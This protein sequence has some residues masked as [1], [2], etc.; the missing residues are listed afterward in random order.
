MTIEPKALIMWENT[1][2]T[3][4]D[5]SHLSKT[6]DFQTDSKFINYVDDLADYSLWADAIL[7]TPWPTPWPTSDASV[8]V[9]TY[10]TI[11][12]TARI[13]QKSGNTYTWIS[14]ASPYQKLLKINA[15]SKFSLVYTSASTGN[16]VYTNFDIGQNPVVVSAESLIIGTDFFQSTNYEIFLYWLNSYG[17]YAHFKIV[18]TTDDTTNT[19]YW[20]QGGTSTTD[21]GV[22]ITSPSGYKLIAMRLVGGFRTTADAIP[23]IDPTSVWDVSTFHTEVASETYKV[24][25]TTQSKTRILQASDIPITDS[26]G[27]YN[28]TDS[29]GALQEA[30]QKI[31]QLNQD[32]YNNQDRFGVELKFSLL[33]YIPNGL[34]LL[35]PTLTNELSIKI[36]AGFINVVETR[37]TID[38]NPNNSDPN[39]NIHDIYLATPNFPLWINNNTTAITT[40]VVLGTRDVTG[41]SRLYPDVWRVYVSQNGQIHLKDSTTVPKYSSTY[42][43]WYDMLTASRC[44]GKFKVTNNGGYYIEK[45]SVTNTYDENIPPNV[46]IIVHGTM[47]PDGML[48]CD[49][50]WHDINGY[51]VNSYPGMPLLSSISDPYWQAGS[52]WEE[53][54]NMWGRTVKMIGQAN[55]IPPT[56]PISTNM[57]AYDTLTGIVTAGGSAETG[58]SSG[59]DIHVHTYSHTHTGGSLT[60]SDP[61]THT[62]S[63]NDVHQQV[64]DTGDI[65]QVASSTGIFVA[66]SL[67]THPYETVTGGGHSHIFSSSSGYTDPPTPLMTDSTSSWAPYKEFL[68]CIKK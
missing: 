49:G 35:Q 38:S 32:L 2:D 61:G 25:D 67:H 19:N 21:T 62:H 55:G 26:A 53:A 43:G 24:F 27:I 44:I 6:I 54:P 64:P 57:F 59:S 51:N 9:V 37:V 12:N 4:L 10:N 16:L 47:C 1:A 39:P 18:R 28:S 20:K 15:K 8:N 66:G 23:K 65:F 17:N 11:D 68:F 29:E 50:L 46:V 48:P 14:T 60:T 33:K 22:D 13:G 56:L 3:P 5:S 7:N 34:P 41:N 45:M 36:T 40:G 52:W 42:H 31:N 30:K 63:A 58:A